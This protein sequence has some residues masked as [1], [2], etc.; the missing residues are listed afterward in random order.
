MPTPVRRRISPSDAE[1]L[2]GGPPGRPPCAPE[3]GGAMPGMGVAAIEAALRS[4]AK[5]SLERAP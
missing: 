2:P 3:G 4:A 5:L 1:R